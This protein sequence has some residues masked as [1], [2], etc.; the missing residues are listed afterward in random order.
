M[1]FLSHRFLRLFP[2]LGMV[3]CFSG[4]VPFLRWLLVGVPEF[5]WPF[6]SSLWSLDWLFKPWALFTSRHCIIMIWVLFWTLTFLWVYCLFIRCFVIFCLC[7]LVPTWIPPWVV[8]SPKGVPALNYSDFDRKVPK[9]SECAFYTPTKTSILYLWSCD[10]QKSTCLCLRS[11]AGPG[12]PIIVL[13][14]RLR[15]TLT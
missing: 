12:L 11:A 4:G 3:D 10:P 9:F 15:L 1:S 8:T 7:L 14:K 5:V 6:P 2:S 13:R